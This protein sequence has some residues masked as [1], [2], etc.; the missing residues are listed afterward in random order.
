MQDTPATMWIPRAET[1]S[2][3]PVLLTGLDGNLGDLKAD[4]R[5]RVTV[6]QYKQQ[7]TEAPASLCA[8]VIECS[9]I[10]TD[11]LSTIYIANVTTPSNI[12]NMGSARVSQQ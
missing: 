8:G 12:Y 2:T 6:T 11:D 3:R 9:S 4:D 1:L 7:K 5:F 10:L